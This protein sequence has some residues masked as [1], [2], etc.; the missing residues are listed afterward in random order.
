MGKFKVFVLVLGLI[1]VNQNARAEELSLGDMMNL[2]SALA[3]GRDVA[4]REAPGIISVITREQIVNSG[5]RDLLEILGLFV[6]GVSFAVDVESITGIGMRGMTA[7][8]GRVLLLIDGIPQNEEV[9]ST[10]QLGN[11]YPAEMVE[12]IEVIRGPGSIYHGQYAQIGVVSVTTR[13]SNQ[14]GQT[15]AIRYSRMQ[16]ADSHRDLTAAYGGSSG[17]LRYSLLVSSGYG[18]P[19]DR[20][21]VDANQVVTNLANKNERSSLFTD[22]GLA[23]KGL[24]V[25]FIYDALHS[26][27]YHADAVMP[28]SGLAEYATYKQKNLKA[29][30]TLKPT[31]SLKLTPKYMYRFTQPYYVHSPDILPDPYYHTLFTERHEV[32]LTADAALSDSLALMAGYTYSHL[33][34]DIEGPDKLNFFPGGHI[35]ESS[36]VFS[37]FTWN[38]P[39]VNVILGARYEA[40]K[41]YDPAF[42]P[43]LSLTKS[44]AKWHYKLMAAQSY[45]MPQGLQPDLTPTADDHLKPETATNY[46]FETGYLFNENLFLVANIFDTHIKDPMVWTPTAGNPKGNYSNQGEIGT[47]GAEAELKY[48]WQKKVELTTH[49]S[50]YK[51]VH[52]NDSIYVVPGH[53]DQYLAFS[54]LRGGLICGYKFTPH[55]GIYPSVSYIGT[56]YGF[57]PSNNGAGKADELQEYTPVYLT[58]I[59]LKT[60]DLV[61]KG[62]EFSA[63]LMNVFDSKVDY[64]QSYNLGYNYPPVPGHSRALNLMLAY[65]REF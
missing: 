37:E 48:K 20:D 26:D 12:R 42:V 50:Y 33:K 61:I 56:H 57:V 19:S 60:E 17:D 29:S 51:R 18:N 49:L 63:G 39:A 13:H 55:I 7:Q 5:A 59:N 44:Y 54:N 3:T 10:L 53:D 30:Y 46:E 36:S 40:P 34:L 35:D 41:N 15:Y 27:S 6:P 38:T 24:D 2:P 8:E 52:S 58:N 11:H 9:Y 25:R 4:R 43:R 47:Q 14:N 62:L 28:A 65:S 22:A 64:S 32:G 1:S 21:Y 16:E 23:Y 31:G 45:R